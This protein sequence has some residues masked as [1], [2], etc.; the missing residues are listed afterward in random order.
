MDKYPFPE[1]GR[2][3]LPLPQ[4]DSVNTAPWATADTLQ[5]SNW[6]RADADY[7]TSH[8]WMV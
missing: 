4:H 8:A 2:A 7:A 6:E 3:G 1:S 5:V